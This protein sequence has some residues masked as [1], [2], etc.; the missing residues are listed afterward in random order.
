MCLNIVVAAQN[1]V[2]RNI[3]D[4]GL[5]G[6]QGCYWRVGLNQTLVPDLLSPNVTLQ[7]CEQKCKEAG[8]AYRYFSVHTVSS[9]VL[10]FSLCF[11]SSD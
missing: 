7:S 9:V 2:V 10:S 1:A 8:N 6:M 11:F 5:L 4:L 3:T